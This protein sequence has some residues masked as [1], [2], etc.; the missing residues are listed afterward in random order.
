MEQ[1]RS[2]NGNDGNGDILSAEGIIVIT[3]IIVMGSQPTALY[4]V[5]FP[6]FLDC[7]RPNFLGVFISQLFQIRQL[8]IREHLGKQFCFH[9]APLI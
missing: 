9:I 2:Y 5:R 1:K 6:Y 3:V 8:F 7:R 4:L